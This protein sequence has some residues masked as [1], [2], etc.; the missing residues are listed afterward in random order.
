MEVNNKRM[1]FI[2]GILITW[3]C[4]KQSTISQS[5]VEV[6]YQTIGYTS[7][8]LQKSIGVALS[9]EILESR[10]M[11]HLLLDVIINPCCLW[12]RIQQQNQNHVI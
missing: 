9:L 11:G 3:V 8:Q 4:K 12:C 6:E 10:L 1:Y 2:S 5:S 7:T